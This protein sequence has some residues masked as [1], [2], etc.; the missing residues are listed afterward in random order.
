MSCELEP[1]IINELKEIMGEDLNFLLEA[2][3]TD[4]QENISQLHEAVD[5][6]CCEDVRQYAH[7]LKGSS[8][9]VG[10]TEVANYCEQLEGSAKQGDLSQGKA[11]LNNISIAFNETKQIIETNYF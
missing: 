8:R 7:S 1:A 10:A 2:Y 4:S 9:N 6:A 5:D 3:L 11:L